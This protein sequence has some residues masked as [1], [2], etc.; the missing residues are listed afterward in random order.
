MLLVK[1]ILNVFLDAL[2]DRTE[3]VLGSEA[4]YTG[5][6]DLERNT[7]RDPALEPRNLDPGYFYF[8]LIQGGCC[9]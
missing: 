9:G 7:L 8:M 5:I 6:I 2:N 1:L 3:A 4:T